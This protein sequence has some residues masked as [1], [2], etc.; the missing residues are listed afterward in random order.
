[1]PE[2]NKQHQYPPNHFHCSPEKPSQYDLV[3]KQYGNSLKE[4]LKNAS[5][6]LIT[7]ATDA[8]TKSAAV[9]TDRR[10]SDKLSAALK[11][12]NFLSI[13]IGAYASKDLELLQT[14][15]AEDVARYEALNTAYTA[16]V[17]A[18]KAAKQKIA[19]VNTLACKLKDAVPDSCNSEELKQIKEC[20]SKNGNKGQQQDSLEESVHKIVHQAHHI[21]NQVDDL[22]ESAVKV[23]GINAFINIASLTPAAALIKEKGTAFI[24]DVDANLKALQTQY[25]SAR[26]TQADALKALSTATTDK[27]KAW[28]VKD[29]LAATAEFVK[30]N[31]CDHDCRSLDEIA[32]EAEQS[33]NRCCG[34]D[35]D[36]EGGEDNP[37]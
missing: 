11:E 23:A 5:D 18:I 33:F 20:L 22:S 13:C 6:I 8:S 12:Y 27:Y 7:K 31:D 25:D 37:A 21:T 34:S 29:G 24:T 36:E 9:C 2:D 28:I 4:S 32:K 19:K 30:D 3:L 15:V 16:A 14:V 35:D 1:M 10:I 26:Q 17:N